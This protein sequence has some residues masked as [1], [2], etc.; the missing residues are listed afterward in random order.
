[1]NVSTLYELSYTNGGF[2]NQ[3]TGFIDTEMT[4]IMDSADP[5][6]AGNTAQGSTAIFDMIN[7]SGSFI[8]NGM[9]DVLG[10][11]SYVIYT[12]KA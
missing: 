12:P 1:M 6:L 5:L 10:M 2:T 4:Y 11:D 7:S 3:H 8:A 9:D